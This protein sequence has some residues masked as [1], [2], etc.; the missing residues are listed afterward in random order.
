MAISLSHLSFQWS[1]QFVKSCGIL[2]V[3]HFS[4]KGTEAFCCLFQQGL[5]SSSQT[6]LSSKVPL[7]SW[8]LTVNSS[9]IS[10]H[11]WHSNLLC[12]HPN[13]VMMIQRHKIFMVQQGRWGTGSDPKSPVGQSTQ[14]V[15]SVFE[16]YFWFLSTWQLSCKSS[17]CNCCL[18]NWK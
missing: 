1:M 5:G 18:P 17:V 7:D 13:V 10:C 15:G 4:L 9:I 14:G 16:I 6:K 8:G 11:L 3:M 12:F 2:A